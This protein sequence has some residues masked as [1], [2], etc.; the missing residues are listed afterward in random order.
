M[1]SV[2]QLGL[3]FGGT[4]LFKD[5][6]FQVTPGQRLGLV[7]RNGAGKSTL[8]RLIAGEMSQDQGQINTP[9]DFK[10]GFLTQD[11][12]VQGER[13]VWD[14]CATSFGDIQQLE[15]DMESMTLEM[16]Q[17]EDFES[18]GY[19]DLIDRFHKAQEHFQQ[20]GGY[21]YQADM[22]RVLMGL[23]FIADDFHKRLDTFSGGWQMRVE[24]AKILLQRND[25]LL[26]D[27]PT[28]HLDLES[29]LWL[30]QF[31]S[32]S[33]QAIILVSH[34]RTF[35]NN[36]TNRTLEIVMGKSYD[37]PA[38]YYKYLV[39]REEIREK[40]RQAK[41]N[42][43]KEIKQTKMLIEKFRYKASK[44]AFAQ[45]LIKQLARMDV[46]AVD[47]EDKRQMRVKFPP[48]PHSGKV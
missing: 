32:E 19:M 27:E 43:D 30:E 25:L 47:D 12:P 1:L 17:R 35:L 16:G 42:Q 46:I 15:I 21:T 26:L 8:L 37:Y 6:S 7:G 33:P 10:I 11:I 22:E 14:E 18:Q 13:T 3:S 5:I 39:L 29:I 36:A 44:A 4:D 24:L 2:H 48:S 23:G 34:D 31:L 40:Q 20:I 38:S 41:F 28:N 45:S 9:T